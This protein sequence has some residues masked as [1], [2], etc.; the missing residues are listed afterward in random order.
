MIRFLH[1]AD[2]HL[3]SP[4][5]GLDA[6]QSEARRQ[7]QK[8]LFRALICHAKNR[9][10]DLLLIAGD[11]F[12][13]GFTTSSTVKFVSD[14]LGTLDCPVII[15]PGN[16]DPYLE[17]GLY[18]SSFPENV[19]IFTSERLSSVYFDKLNVAVHGYAFTSERHEEAPLASGVTVDPSKINILCAHTELD[20]PHSPYAP[21][22]S[23]QL[24]ESGFDY[25]AL[26][27]IHNPPKEKSCEKTLVCY[28]GCLEGRSFDELGYGGAVEVT[29]DG[30]K[31]TSERIRLAKHRYMVETLDITGANKD[32][33]VIERIRQRIAFSNYQEDTALRVILTGAISP[34]YTPALA[35]ITEEIKGLYRLNIKDRSTPILDFTELEND[36]SIRG[37]Y[38]RTL[39][40]KMRSSDEQERQVAAE[41]LRIGLC[42]LS[43]KP[44]VF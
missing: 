30:T 12:D 40:A 43:G 27:H 20:A 16:H 5:S 32:I 11:L 17:G 36:M 15:T 22:T 34:D 37:E 2:L 28:S 8:D 6:I 4:F 25:A 13:S 19:I 33:D 3:D 31:V 39:V 1:C 7:E 24:A 38:Y 26:G 21:I 44:I 9:R 10:V 35:Y 23:K 14:M 29:V 41:A 18:S 42:A